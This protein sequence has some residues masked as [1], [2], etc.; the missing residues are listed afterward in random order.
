MSSWLCL[1]AGLNVVI[2]SSP[3]ES[4]LFILL[5]ELLKNNP[6]AQCQTLYFERRNKV[7]EHE[8]KRTKE[9][10]NTLCV[11]LACVWQAYTPSINSRKRHQYYCSGFARCPRENRRELI[12]VLNLTHQ[13]ECICILCCLDTIK[14]NII[15]TFKHLMS[16]TRWWWNFKF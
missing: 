7:Y 14:P 5:N 2:K 11:P 13:N 8:Q 16:E 4:R 15:H 9:N 10:C 6:T 1:S 12:G 3:N